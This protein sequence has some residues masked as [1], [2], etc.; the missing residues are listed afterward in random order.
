[1]NDSFNRLGLPQIKRAFDKLGGMDVVTAITHRDF[2]FEKKRKNIPA[3]DV[4]E[5]L[6]SARIYASL[7]HRKK[8]AYPSF[9]QL[10]IERIRD[11]LRKVGGIKVLQAYLKG[12][13]VLVDVRRKALTTIGERIVPTSLS[14]TLGVLVKYDEPFEDVFVKRG[15]DETPPSYDV[16]IK[17]RVRSAINDEELFQ[18]LPRKYLFAE[19]SFYQLLRALIQ[20][21]REQDKPALSTKES[22]IFFV[23]LFD[24]SVVKVVLTKCKRSRES[25]WEI[26]MR[27]FDKMICRS[28]SYVFTPK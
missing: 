5:A 23:R 9:D 18:F 17:H 3:L 24:K 16:I 19:A 8:Q 2:A 4:L 12:T 20:E 1:M 7:Y 28:F 21:E 25:W 10:T 13:H 22:N 6:A 26:R 11:I 14:E 15:S 27:P